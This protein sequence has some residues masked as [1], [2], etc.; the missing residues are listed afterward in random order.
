MKK[1]S[2]KIIIVVL[3]IAFFIKCDF[4]HNANPVLEPSATINL[5]TTKVYRKILI[6]DY[7]GHKC[8]NCPRA[9]DTLNYL[10]H[11]YGDKIVSLAVHAGG[12]ATV[13][14]NY[15]TDLR[16]TSGNDYDNAFGFA[17]AGNP[18]GLVN[19]EGYLPTDAID[20][21]KA[22][23]VWESTALT[24]FPKLADFKIEIKNTFNT[25]NN[26]LNTDV[27]IKALS[28]LNGN[29]KLVILLSED[30][31]IGEQLDYEKPVGSQKITDYVF[32][33]VLRGAINS[34]W[35][36]DVFTTEVV[37][38][39]SVSKSYSYVLNTSY[40]S[41]HCHVIAYIYDADLN[42]PTYYE[43]LQV[44]EKQLN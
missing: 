32:N 4:V 14:P 8:G 29:Y 31:I 30:S 13:N 3:T 24:Y 35:G 21:I 23:P 39:N 18:N 28:N 36:D 6:E 9:A 19:R 27:T 11:K 22:Y 26:V 5:D 40:K 43:V 34:T 38:N 41:N 12:F 20:F 42:S 33:H 2:F 15:P 1:I 44:E 25:N 37:K 17:T 7:T 16:S 10:H